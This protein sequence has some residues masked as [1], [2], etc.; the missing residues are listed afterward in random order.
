M[1]DSDARTTNTGAAHISTPA[2]D[3]A[4]A[5]LRARLFSAAPS[6]PAHRATML[7]L[8]CF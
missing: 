6:P 2:T 3:T 8:F 4:S 1:S 5:G 7:E